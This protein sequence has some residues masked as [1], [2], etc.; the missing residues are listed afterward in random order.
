MVISCS[1]GIGNPYVPIRTDTCTGS[2]NEVLDSEP[3][4]SRIILERLEAIVIE[5]I[6]YDDSAEH[7]EYGRGK[8]GCSDPEGERLPIG[9]PVNGDRSIDGP[10]RT[11]GQ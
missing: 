7:V 9:S 3:Q 6:S 4:G 8:L 5:E 11:A 1:N 2:I 10:R